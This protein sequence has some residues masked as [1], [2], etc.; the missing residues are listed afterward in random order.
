MLLFMDNCEKINSLALMQYILHKI[1]ILH[2]ERE[3]EIQK[4]S[5]FKSVLK[6]NNKN[7]FFTS[8]A[9]ELDK[10]ALKKKL[11]MLLMKHLNA[12]TGDNIESKK[13]KIVLTC[14]FISGKK[15]LKIYQIKYLPRSLTGYCIDCESSFTRFFI[16]FT[17]I[18]SSLS[19][20]FYTG[21]KRNKMFSITM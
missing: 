18:M 8:Q 2:F 7:Y 3:P 5:H 17:H 14:T 9:E 11:H 19:H 6:S 20:C 13:Q 4:Y 10:K 16:A 1:I 21:I 15:Y 12:T